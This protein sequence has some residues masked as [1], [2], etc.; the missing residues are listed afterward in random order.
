[1]PCNLWVISAITALFVLNVEQGA[2]QL[3]SFNT[4]FGTANVFSDT[5]PDWAYFISNI[6]A[7]LIGVIA[8]ALLVRTF[9]F[10]KLARN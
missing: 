3:A 8:D 5:N 7:L 4:I 1:M 6:N 2:V 10:E 9:I